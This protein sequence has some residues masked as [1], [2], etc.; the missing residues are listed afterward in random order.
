MHAND[1]SSGKQIIIPCFI[2][3]SIC[4]EFS[5][6]SFFS[7]CCLFLSSSFGIFY[8]KE[9]VKCNGTEGRLLYEVV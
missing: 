5:L 3:S 2:L 8:T 9:H 4:F 1:S 6:S 7:S